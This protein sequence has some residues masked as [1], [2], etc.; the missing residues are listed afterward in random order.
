MTAIRAALG[1]GAGWFSKAHF[2]PLI[3]PGGF[4]D[5][6]VAAGSYAGAVGRSKSVKLLV[7]L[8]FSKSIKKI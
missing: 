4:A 8:R 3:T 6:A 1:S 2:A 5:A 7:F